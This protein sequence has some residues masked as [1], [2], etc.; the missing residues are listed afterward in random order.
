M[1]I[2]EEKWNLRL[3]LSADN[4]LSAVP[5]NIRAQVL[6]ALLDLEED[7]F[8]PGN[9]AMRGWKNLYRIRIEG[10]RIVYQV[11]ARDRI[12]LVE[13]IKPRDRVY[14]GLD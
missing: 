10:Y 11:N 9:V 1:G 3:S 4:D 5:G 2:S 6:D 8:P 12:V 13:R 7:P 14:R